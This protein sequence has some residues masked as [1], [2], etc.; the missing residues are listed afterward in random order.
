MF[1][2]QR[3]AADIFNIGL[4]EDRCWA[5]ASEKKSS[6]SHQLQPQRETDRA[7]TKRL[8]TCVEKEPS[9]SNYARSHYSFLTTEIPPRKKDLHLTFTV[10]SLSQR[11]T[12]SAVQLFPEQILLL[13]QQPK[14]PIKASPESKQSTGSRGMLSNLRGSHKCVSKR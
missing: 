10:W 1:P 7:N 13:R 2:H 12:A 11:K 3:S 5:A 14:P 4:P 8:G 6:A 9:S